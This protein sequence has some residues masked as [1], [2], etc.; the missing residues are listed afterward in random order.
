MKTIYLKIGE[1]KNPGIEWLKELENH[2]EVCKHCSFTV[3]KNEIFCHKCFNILIKL[4][5]FCNSSR[6][7]ESKFHYE[8]PLCKSYF[9]KEV[10]IV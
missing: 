8:C 10:V 9:E 6:L 5:P 2:K 7:K 1:S 3:D 4:C